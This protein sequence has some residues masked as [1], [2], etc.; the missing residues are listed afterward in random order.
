MKSRLSPEQIE[1]EL[2]GDLIQFND[3]STDSLTSTSVNVTWRVFKS[4]SLIDGFRIRYRPVGI[5]EYKT[6]IISESKKRSALVNGLL[7]FTAYEM[8]IEPFSG[9]IFGSES[10]TIQFKTKDDGNFDIKEIK[11]TFSLK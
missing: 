1:K 3:V 8:S 4:A 2:N 9:E 11:M 6:E 7:K 5:S 10:N